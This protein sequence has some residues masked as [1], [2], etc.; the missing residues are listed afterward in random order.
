M[1]SWS[2][3]HVPSSKAQLANWRVPPLHGDVATGGL[4][5]YYESHEYGSWDGDL[6]G[7]SDMVCS[8]FRFVYWT[9]DACI[10]HAIATKS[11]Q[12]EDTIIIK[13]H[14]WQSNI[15]R[16]SRELQEDFLEGRNEH[17]QFHVPY[18]FFLCYK[19]QQLLV[20]WYDW[21]FVFQ[22]TA[23]LL[24]LI[25]LP[26]SNITQSQNPT[27]QRQ[28]RWT[29]MMGNRHAIMETIY[30]GSPEMILNAKLRIGRRCGC[31]LLV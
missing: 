10:P 16:T 30:W 12:S 22:S 13:R 15:S 20:A 27:T 25:Y 29:W 8:C 11:S 26:S 1:E 9:S 19:Y 2:G 3:H 6:W 5:D 21:M 18:R 23:I 7:E 17:S 14:R 31:I 4:N 28:D 24:H